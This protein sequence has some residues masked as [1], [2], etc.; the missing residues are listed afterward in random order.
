MCIA[1]YQSPGQQVTRSQLTNCWQA[2]SH[3]AGYMF[4]ENG[5]LVIRKGYMGNEGLHDL[6]ADYEY[7]LQQHPNAPFALHFRIA[8]HGRQDTV[9]CHPHKVWDDVA[10]VHNGII[11]IQSKRAWVNES[12]S[13]SAQ[14][15]MFMKSRMPKDAYLRKR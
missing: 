14:Y 8:T 11:P 2:N 3:G 9:N 5:E 13:D 4:A 12:F 1:I 6:V 10:F 7:D 15:A